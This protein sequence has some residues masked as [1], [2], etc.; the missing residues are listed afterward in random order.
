MAE[1]TLRD[2][3][4]SLIDIRDETQVNTEAVEEN[5]TAV[6]E[7]TEASTRYFKMFDRKMDEDRLHR[8]EER[9]EWMARFGAKK[10]A[11]D[12]VRVRPRRNTGNDEDSFSDIF[13]G[14]FLGNL[15]A[16]VKKALAPFTVAFLGNIIRPLRALSRLVLRNGPLAITVALLWT[17][18]RDIGE[19]PEFR[20]A[21][22]GIR[23]VWTNTVVPAWIRL[24]EIFSDF[25]STEG[26]QNAITTISG[27]W[28]EITGWFTGDFQDGMQGLLI[29]IIDGIGGV[30]TT[31]S[32]FLVRFFEGDILGAFTGLFTDIG[33][34]VWDG[35]DSISTR[36]LE[37]FGVNFGDGESA[38]SGIR[39]VADDIRAG[40][41]LWIMNF[42]DQVRDIKDSVTGWITGIRE[43]IALRFGEA[44]DFVT[45]WSTEIGNTITERF[46]EARDWMT[47][48]F[49]TVGN[50][51]QSMQIRFENAIDRVQI[52]FERVGNFIA[53]IPDR[54]LSM[55]GSILDFQI[56]RL[57]LPY[58]NF[59]LGQGEIVLF[60][61]GRPFSGVGEVGEAAQTRIESRSN[62]M[63]DSISRLEAQIASRLEELNNTNSDL[64]R[65]SG[66][67]GDITVVAPT[68]NSNVQNTSTSVMAFPSPNNEYAPQ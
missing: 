21:I 61:G 7:L 64:S 63:N 14:T 34:L 11:N 53:N 56:P 36:L 43:T 62:V 50:V 51:L 40:A 54:L 31:M 10:P 16:S 48:I 33:N 57:A 25:I 1:T 26:V 32:N 45:E 8:E 38:L 4:D 58:D 9:R 20:A 6:G 23:D 47:N 46:G 18:F 29:D 12:N 52:G 65:G 13:A 68:T 28:Q 44:R 30:L 59:L 15:A 55:I 24:S 39:G 17:T 35:V 60:P 49:D 66:G 22:E 41:L 27:I 67:M 19:N 42:G 5:K 3:V 37:M 2:V